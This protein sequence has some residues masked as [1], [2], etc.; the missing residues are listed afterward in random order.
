M[1]V[2]VGEAEVAALEAVAKLLVVEAADAMRFTVSS[3]IG[4]R[5][6]SPANA[7]RSSP[8]SRRAL[9]SAFSS[10]IDAPSAATLHA[11]SPRRRSPRP[12]CS[13]AP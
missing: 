12:S 8:V 6:V 3:G 7:A 13:R 4:W 10:G 9:P 1:A 5:A 11:E 2:N